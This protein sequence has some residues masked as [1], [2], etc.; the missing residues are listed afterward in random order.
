MSTNPDPSAEGAFALNLDA[1]GVRSAATRGSLV[2]ASA[3]AAKAGLMFAGQL[4]LARL[5]APSDFGL[6]A[7]VGPVIAFAGIL[8]NLGLASSLVQRQVIDQN[9]V[10]AVFWGSLAISIGLYAMLCITAPLVAWIYGDPAVTTLILVNSLLVPLSALGS[11]PIALLNRRMAFWKLQQVEVIGAAVALAATAGLAFARFGYWSLT[12]G[13]LVGNG[14]GAAMLWRA[15]RWRPSRPSNWRA[16]VEDLS[17]GANLTG[18]NLAN[19]VTSTADNVIIGSLNGAQALGYYDRSYK[20]VV[21]PINQILYPVSSVADPLLSRLQDDPVAYAHSYRMLLRATFL[22][23]LPPAIY[24]AVM[25]ERVI[26]LLLGQRWLPAAPTFAWIAIGGIA[27]GLYISLSWLMISQRRA[28]TMRRVFTLAAIVNVTAFSAGSFWGVEGV[29]AFGALTFLFLTTPVAA[30]QATRSGPVTGT[31]LVRAVIPYA[32][33]TLA[34]FVGL[35]LVRPYLATAALIWV[36]TSLTVLAAA[37]ALPLL[38]FPAERV[39]AGHVLGLV[40]RRM[41]RIAERATVPPI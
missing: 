21:Q 31:L 18:A 41:R 10:S 14:I 39:E 2:V 33:A 23:S 12:L 35:E 25:G 9:R 7:M 40:S 19:F 34:S 1:G 22:L 16:A 13:S 27:S 30:F 5:L 4:V 6:V 26:P 36:P 32:M 28:D 24:C 8:G 37:F 38:V 29:A 20:L 17:F 11:V 15:C 3:Q